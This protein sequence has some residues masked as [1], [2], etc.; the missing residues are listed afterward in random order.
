MG[1]GEQKRVNVLCVW[2]L[3]V[4]CLTRKSDS[5]LG[6]P[7]LKLTVLLQ[8]AS[9]TSTLKESCEQTMQ[10]RMW[11]WAK[12]TQLCGNQYPWCAVPVP[13]VTRAALAATT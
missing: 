2:H 3:E 12:R 6:Y 11:R 8:N 10:S 5:Q 13:G 4:T 9:F 7:M 1:P